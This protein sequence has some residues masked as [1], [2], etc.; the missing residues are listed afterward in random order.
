MSEPRSQSSSGADT[1]TCAS[2]GSLEVK[3]YIEIRKES[4]KHENG[5]FSREPY[6]VVECQECGHETAQRVNNL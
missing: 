2:C 5:K 3:V 4:P 1:D 6:R